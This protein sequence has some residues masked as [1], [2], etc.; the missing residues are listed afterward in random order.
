MKIELNKSPMPFG[1]TVFGH[2][3]KPGRKKKEASPSPMPFGRTV[4]GHTMKDPRKSRKSGLQCL[5]A[6]PSL[7]TLHLQ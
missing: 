7:V 4:F 6:G 1:R 3:A 5:S 2:A